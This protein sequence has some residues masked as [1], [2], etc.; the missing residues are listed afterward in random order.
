MEDNPIFKAVNSYL[1]K[2]LLKRDME[3]QEGITAESQ[4]IILQV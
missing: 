2:I 3:Q 4:A 1:S